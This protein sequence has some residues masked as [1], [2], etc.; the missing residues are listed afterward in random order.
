MALKKS[1]VI[2][3]TGVPATHHVVDGVNVSKSSKITNV[4]VLSYYNES[5]LTAGKQPVGSP[6]SIMIEAI[7]PDGADSFAFAEK[8]LVQ[9]APDD[10][11]S[12]SP[13]FGVQNRYLFAGAE[14]IA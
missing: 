14:I 1:I 8:A 13:T 7:P 3:A 5:T 12:T 11:G 2:D 6:I 10:G 4:I 9:K